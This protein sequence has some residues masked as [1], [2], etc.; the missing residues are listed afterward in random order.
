PSRPEPD[1]QPAIGKGRTS[2]VVLQT[3]SECSTRNIHIELISSPFGCQV[4]AV[5]KGE[6]SALIK[7]IIPLD[8]ISLQLNLNLDPPCVLRLIDFRNNKIRCVDVGLD[9]N[10]I[11]GPNCFIIDEH[12]PI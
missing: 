2:F 9:R 12:I 10:P 8:E 5:N 7:T 11:V 6:R 3:N 4:L 1:P